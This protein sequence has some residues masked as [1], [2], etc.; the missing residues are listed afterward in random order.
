M[1]KY[2]ET[3][4]PFSSQPSD[5]QHTMYGKIYHE[6]HQCEAI[7]LVMLGVRY[8][9]KQLKSSCLVGNELIPSMTINRASGLLV[10]KLNLRPKSCGFLYRLIQITR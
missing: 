5:G 6:G 7:F 4:A 9:G 3:F 1:L 10:R 8:M 2:S